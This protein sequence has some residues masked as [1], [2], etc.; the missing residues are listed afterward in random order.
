[1]S[2][3]SVDRQAIPHG[4]AVNSDTLN[5]TCVKVSSETGFVRDTSGTGF[6]RIAAIGIGG[7]EAAMAG[8][9]KDDIYTEGS[10]ATSHP[11][12]PLL[13]TSPEPMN[14]DSH[15]GYG[16]ASA[17]VPLN[18]DH[19][20]GRQSKSEP[21]LLSS[22][23]IRHNSAPIHHHIAPALGAPFMKAEG[24]MHRGNVLCP[25]SFEIFGE[26]LS[27]GFR[28]GN[29]VLE[30]FGSFALKTFLLGKFC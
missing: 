2:I 11:S 27:F 13:R 4:Q 30:V 19:G 8:G 25:C 10:S 15:S 6:E 28:L 17:V 16:G 23:G 5:Y 21:G 24:L 14:P 20:L 9:Y 1:M 26:S 7:L 18:R 29:F 3:Q 22:G 12:S